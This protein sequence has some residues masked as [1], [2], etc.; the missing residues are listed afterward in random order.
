MRCTAIAGSCKPLVRPRASGFGESI[1]RFE[2]IVDNDDVATPTGQR[3]ADRCRQPK[4]PRRKFNL[5]LIV[6]EGANSRSGKGRSIP[7]R[8]EH[9]AEVVGMLFCKLSRIASTNDATRRFKPENEGR[10][11]D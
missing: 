8:F 3:A 4:T 6:F 10:E 7:R 9:G 11:G 2:G 5:C 1:V